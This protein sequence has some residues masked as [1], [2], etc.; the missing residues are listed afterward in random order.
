MTSSVIDAILILTCMLEYYQTDN[1]LPMQLKETIATVDRAI[2]KRL[3]N[4]DGA[5]WLQK[6]KHCKFG[7]QYQK[8]RYSRKQGLCLCCDVD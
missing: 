2:G 4:V 8:R 5:I 1:T 6:V 7:C 3:Q